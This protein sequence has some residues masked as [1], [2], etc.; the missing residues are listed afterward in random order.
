MAVSDQLA[1]GN[2]GDAQA[3]ASRNIRRRQG[4]VQRR[5]R[6]VLVV[7]GID[8]VLEARARC[9]VTRQ[10]GIVEVGV[11]GDNVVLVIGWQ[12]GV[13]GECEALPKSLGL[14]ERRA[15]TV[16]GIDLGEVPGTQRRHLPGSNQRNDG[17]D[18]LV[19]GGCA[20]VAQVPVG[21]Q[22]L[23]V[24]Q[25][26][27][28][29]QLGD[30]A[31]AELGYR[32]QGVPGP[33]REGL[34]AAA[35]VADFR[36]EQIDRA[37][38][39]GD[40]QLAGFAGA[41]VNHHAANGRGREERGRVVGR[42]IGVAPWNTVI[43]DVVF[44][45]LEPA[46]GALGLAKARAVER[47]ARHAG[48]EVDDLGV[49]GCGRDE[50]VDGLAI[51]DRLRLRRGERS[52]YRGRGRRGAWCRDD[53]FLHPRS[54]VCVFR[55]DLDRIHGRRGG[56]GRTTQGQ[57]GSDGDERAGGELARAV[58]EFDHYG[59][60]RWPVGPEPRRPGKGSSAASRG[61]GA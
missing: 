33:N 14:I 15:R 37:T 1:I 35:H 26:L 49:V 53:Q 2:Q 39:A 45:V 52:L 7:V 54:V 10:L 6:V 40:A 3:L 11:F 51:N 24:Q 55:I 31:A 47:G 34:R 43:G 30:F 5:F 58:V 22:L 61:A 13:V 44:A 60:P 27:S 46:Q 42:A 56:E 50:L 9:H 59:S 18:Q 38:E 17:A 41:A 20:A 28:I 19:I 32:R 23:E 12:A 16:V 8:R 57:G 25:K 48:R 4:R 29:V 36:R 21:F